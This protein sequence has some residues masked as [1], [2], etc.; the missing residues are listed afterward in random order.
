MSNIVI[1]CPDTNI[2]LS[3]DSVERSAIRGGKSAI[4][5]LA[6]S[7]AHSGHRVSLFSGRVRPGSRPGFEVRPLDEVDG[8]FDVAVYVTGA[9]GHFRDP[10]IARIRARISVFWINGPLRVEPPQ[11]IRLDWSVAPA[12]FLA[13]R[14]IDEWGLP[15]DRVVVIPGE[16]VRERWSGQGGPARTP[17]LGAYASHPSKGLREAVSV[18]TRLRQRHSDLRLDVFG[19]EA[20]WGAPLESFSACPD[21]VRSMGDVPEL[22]VA[23]RL[24]SHGFMP[25]FTDW[26]D[27][28][29]LATAEAL[30]AGVLVFAT[31]H[32]SNAE[33]VRHGWN[34]FLIRAVDGRP[35]LGQ[36][37]ELMARYLQE[38][39]AFE[40][41]RH[42]ARRSVQTWDEQAAEWTRVWE[43]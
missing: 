22:E 1:V 18:L 28:F 13:R 39:E 16:A 42:N 9:L 7:W 4:V 11:G 27:G 3:V 23:T 19:S 8:C 29:S 35:D 43:R 25:Y 17:S 12:R 31:A 33:F 41:I 36:A 34:G 37:G 30:A 26:L 40:E 32:G 14:A 10:R 5:Q 38:P 24:R 21:W 6:T 20:L 15:A 2:E